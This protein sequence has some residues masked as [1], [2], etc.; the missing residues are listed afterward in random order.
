MP[1]INAGPWPGARW[2][3]LADGWPGPSWLTG[4]ALLVG[5]AAKKLPIGCTGLGLGQVQP[6]VGTADHGLH[7]QV[8]ARG[9]AW[10]RFGR[11]G[12]TV[13]VPPQRNGH[14]QHQ[15]DQQIFTHAPCPSSTS[16]TKREPA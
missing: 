1:A 6:A 14:Q 13:L 2:W 5:G 4:T 8:V 7:R 10:A 3:C 15:R 16:S 12:F 9:R 11:N